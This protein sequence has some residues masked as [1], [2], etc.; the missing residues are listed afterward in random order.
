MAATLREGWRDG[1]PMQRCGHAKQGGAASFRGL[2]R[3]LHLSLTCGILEDE[4]GQY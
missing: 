1:T 2:Q 3:A 4:D